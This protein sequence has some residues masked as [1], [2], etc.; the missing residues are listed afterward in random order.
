M[1]FWPTTEKNRSLLPEQPRQHLLKLGYGAQ[2]PLNPLLIL[3]R[4]GDI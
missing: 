3:V 1:T 2:L 4:F